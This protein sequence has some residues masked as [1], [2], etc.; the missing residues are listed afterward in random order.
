MAGKAGSTAIRTLGSAGRGMLNAK[1]GI[2]LGLLFHS[3]ELNKGETDRII[4]MKQQYA[5]GKGLDA[6]R[7][8][9]GIGPEVGK[10]AGEAIN[11]AGQAAA[12]GLQQAGQAVSNNADAVGKA[13]IAQVGQ[14]KI[15]GQINVSVSASPMLQVQTTAVGNGNTTLNVG[16][17]NTGA[18]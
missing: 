10:Q 17:T 4:A 13:L 12:Q 7:L 16:K 18:K 1:T 5:A 9:M 15:Q 8:A 14:T 3:E 11:Q 2:G 6:K